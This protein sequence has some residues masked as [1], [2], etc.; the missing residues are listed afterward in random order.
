MAKKAKSKSRQAK[1]QGVEEVFRDLLGRFAGA[2]GLGAVGQLA[3]SAA[4]APQAP[5]MV[6]KTRP[7]RNKA[8]RSATRSLVRES[9]PRLAQASSHMVAAAAQYMDPLNHPPVRLPDVSS[10][11]TIG[12]AVCALSSALSLSWGQEDSSNATH[13]STLSTA[14]TVLTTNRMRAIFK[15]RDPVVACIVTEFGADSLASTPTVYSL[16]IGA[17]AF[18][19]TFLLNGGVPAVKVSE[20]PLAIPFAIMSAVSGP[21][22]YPIQV[23]C[24]WVNDSVR[25]FWVDASPTNYATVTVYANNKGTH[26]ITMMALNWTNAHTPTA[27]NSV[28]INTGPQTVSLTIPVSGYWSLNVLTESQPANTA[29]TLELS[30]VTVAVGVTMWCSHHCHDSMLDGI[31]LFHDVR[32]LGDAVL[33]SNT[34]SKFFQNGMVYARQSQDEAPWFSFAQTEDEYT[35]LNVRE[36]YQGRLEKGIYATVKPQGPETANPFGMINVVDR[37]DNDELPLL[38]FRPFQCPGVVSI[39]LSP[40]QAAT[41][42]AATNVNIHFMRS[43]EYTTN[44]QLVVVDTSRLPRTE[45]PALLD[46][47]AS[48][49]QFFENP[50]H[51]QQIR[52]KLHEMGAWVWRNRSEIAAIVA[53]LRAIVAAA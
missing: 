26:A 35:S 28:V 9:V 53:A 45:F 31:T 8:S 16:S 39:L 22:R 25:A 5:P 21:V 6:P 20:V 11:Q 14:E 3:K 4:S 12:T 41:T 47:L 18:G 15:L 33:V 40:A 30:N 49:P 52:Q 1:T 10:A 42:D 13:W 38:G 46:A 51:L 37:N 24:C 48:C 29:I 7:S 34:T 2:G 19:E 50:L 44:S 36:L 32:V 23:P 17:Q 27:G 43:L